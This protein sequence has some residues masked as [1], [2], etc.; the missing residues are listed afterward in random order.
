MLCLLILGL[1]AF[2]CTMYLV[3][4]LKSRAAAL[5]IYDSFCNINWHLGSGPLIGKTEPYSRFLQF[6][7][8]L[9]NKNLFC[10]GPQS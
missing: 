10:G 5:E 2:T 1:K 9:E 8:T 6:V 4:A 7:I 3:H